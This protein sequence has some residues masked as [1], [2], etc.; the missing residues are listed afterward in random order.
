M[1]DATRSGNRGRFINHACG[2][3]NCET[4]KWKVRGRD[5]VGIFTS[6]GVEAGEE[7]TFDYNWQRRGGLRVACHCNKPG[8]RGWLGE[9]EKGKPNKRRRRS[10]T[11]SRDDERKTAE[12]DSDSSNSEGEGKDDD[13]EEKEEEEDEKE[14]QKSGETE[15]EEE[16][17]TSPEEMASVNRQRGH[18]NLLYVHLAEKWL[19]AL[20]EAPP[21]ASSSSSSAS[22]LSTF[23]ASVLAR[24]RAA[25]ARQ[26]E[27]LLDEVE[28]EDERDQ[29]TQSR[30]SGAT[31]GSESD[32]SGNAGSQQSQVVSVR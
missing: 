24:C 5:V 31:R 8:C 27:A 10:P 21:S 32:V 14:E 20:D 23:D 29:L 13:D 30:S 1:I 18:D 22:S 15:D 12:M 26:L 4:V 16:V 17:R 19:R 11:R 3:N 28:V 7:L 25:R 6:R 9:E 2:D